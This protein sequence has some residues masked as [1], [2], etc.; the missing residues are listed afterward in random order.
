MNRCCLWPGCRSGYTRRTQR[1]AAASE[2]AVQ[3][4]S[5][6]TYADPRQ[7][8]RSSTWRR[9]C[10]ELGHAQQK[11]SRRCALAAGTTNAV[12]TV[13]L[14]AASS[15]TV[16][17]DYASADGT[18]TAGSDYTALSGTLTFA[19]GETSQTIT[20]AVIGDTINEPNETF[21]VNL[22]N[23]SNA[24]VA[25]GQGRATILNDDPAP[26]SLAINDVTVNEG[27]SGVTSAI[28]TVTLSAASTQ[29]VTVNFASADG[30]AKAATRDYGAVSGTLTFAPGQTTQPIAVPIIGDKRKEK[31]ETFFVNLSGPSNATIADGQGR[32]T[33]INDD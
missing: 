18:A 5:A 14:S 17:V 33:I 28:F 10:N 9:D 3:T 7:L 25:D 31:D 22:S 1:S 13:S 4:M 15:T 16:T 27:D 20:A 6:G 8:T 23:P 11:P 32:G 24:T 12:F 26:P 2:S 21:V 30:S 19:P 29:T